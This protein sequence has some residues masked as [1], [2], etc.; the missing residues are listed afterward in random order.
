MTKEVN[1]ICYTLRNTGRRGRVRITV[2]SDGSVVVSKSPRIAIADAEKFVREKFAWIEAKIREQASRPK[3][4][5]AH[6]S[7]KDFHENKERAR[8]FALA[9]LA[10]FNTFYNHRI[11]SVSIRSQKSRWGSCS[12]KGNLSFNYKIVFLP[13]ALADYLI[14]HE[15]CHLGE[16]NHSKK[17]WMLVA[18][19]IPDYK[20]LRREMKLF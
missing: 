7:V 1:G 8:A 17:F 15:L 10:H 14:V 4:L 12:R 3:R 6:Y 16:M 19:K 20:A 5:L 9:R 18:Q 11:G 2:K 13:P